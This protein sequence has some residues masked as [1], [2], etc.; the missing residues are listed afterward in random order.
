M[1]YREAT[2]LD[3]PQLLALEQRVI[4]AERVLNPSIKKYNT[5]YYDLNDLIKSDDSY[6]I[7]GEDNGRIVATGYSQ[8]RV[9][10]RWHEH[11]HHAYL[12]FMFV[13]PDYRGQGLNQQVID[14]LIVWSKAKGVTDFYLEVLADNTPAIKAYEKLGFAPCIMEMKLMTE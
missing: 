11:E 6:L 3:Q 13:S 9:S 8:I 7:V 12:G 4:D 2:L 5:S 10:D 1:I 14:Q